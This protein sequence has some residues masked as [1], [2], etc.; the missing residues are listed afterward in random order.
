MSLRS[1]RA[2]LLPLSFEFLDWISWHSF[3][4][5]VIQQDRPARYSEV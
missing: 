5:S 1:I 3:I 4:A 2:T